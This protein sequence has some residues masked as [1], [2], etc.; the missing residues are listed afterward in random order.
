MIEQTGSPKDLYSD[1]R[2]LFAADFMGMN[3]RIEGTIRAAA[4]G[5]ASL[6]IDGAVLE[7]EARSKALASGRPGTAIIRIE[8]V[9]L[10][11]SPG[12]NRVPMH[13]ETAMYLGERF[14]LLLR[15]GDWTV[16]AFAHEP[17]AS[18]EQLVEFPREALWI[19]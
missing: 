16:R 18:D 19:F 10:A 5:S 1:P 14:E 15:R 8:R 11:D 9:M 3:N 17:P 7:G 4:N 13:I 6:E 12:P 2:S